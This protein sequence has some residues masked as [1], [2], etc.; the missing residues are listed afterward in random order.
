MHE[1]LDIIEGL[2]SQEDF[3]YKGETISFGPS[4]SVPRPIQRPT[5]PIWVSGRNAQSVGWLLGRGYNLLATPWREPFSYVENSYG[6]FTELRDKVGPK[7]KRQKYGISRM[8]FVGETD[9]EAL[10]A[11]RDVAINH[12]AFTRLFTNTAAVKAGFVQTDPVE[13]EF[14]EEQLLSNL[15]A[16]S[17]ETVIEKLKAYEALG[18]DEFIMYAGFPLDE[19]KIKKSIRLFAE[20]VMPAFAKGK[21]KGQDADDGRIAAA[22]G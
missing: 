10:E 19:A 13:N 15:V 6:Q 22:A 3:E 1:G 16:G 17:P 12:R 8:S 14:T 5:P 2:L 20:R 21:T 18:V 7:G 9:G 11:M 4:T